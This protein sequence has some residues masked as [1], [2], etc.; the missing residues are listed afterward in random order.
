MRFEHA[1]SAF[2]IVTAAGPSVAASVAE[3]MP[4][5]PLVLSG[6][7]GVPLRT[8]RAGLTRDIN[9]FLRSSYLQTH[10]LTCEN[11]KKT[12]LYFFTIGSTTCIL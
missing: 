10:F 5:G 6:P 2:G 7:P 12:R 11:Q 1:H 9:L 3:K 4:L 8:C